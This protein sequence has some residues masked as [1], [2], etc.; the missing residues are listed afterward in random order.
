ML[1]I[2]SKWMNKWI[3]QNKNSCIYLKNQNKH[4]RHVF[5][6]KRTAN[7]PSPN[8]FLLFAICRR[9]SSSSSS[10]ISCSVS[11]WPSLSPPRWY[12]LKLNKK[13]E[14]KKHFCF[15]AFFSLKTGMC[16]HIQMHMHEK[17]VCRKGYIDEHVWNWI[18]VYLL[19]I[20]EKGTL[21]NSV[22]SREM[23]VWLHT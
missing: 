2:L 16:M 3:N 15:P 6:S 4:K 20:N 18:Y 19:N 8:N 13:R 12:P 9:R 22:K 14:I 10:S 23:L 11:S 17:C 1:Q 7:S 21:N 5:N